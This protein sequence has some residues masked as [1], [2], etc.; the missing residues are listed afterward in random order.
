MIDAGFYSVSSDS[1]AS[2]KVHAKLGLDYLH[3]SDDSLF[4]KVTAQ[5]TLFAEVRESSPQI[6]PTTTTN[7]YLFLLLEQLQRDLRHCF[8]FK[9]RIHR[10]IKYLQVQINKKE[11]WG[12][13]DALTGIRS[14][15]LGDITVLVSVSVSKLHKLD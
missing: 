13:S 3:T 5:I 2:E 4:V 7:I 12:C 6:S 14:H 9:N 1:V 10:K 11:R 15:Y 8:C